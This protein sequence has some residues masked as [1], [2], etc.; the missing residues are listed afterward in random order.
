LPK[1]APEDGECPDGFLMNSNGQCF[2]DKPCP[3]GFEKRDEDETGRCYPITEGP[4][5][6]PIENQTIEPTP[7]GNET[8]ATN[9]T[10]PTPTLSTTVNP[11]QISTDKKTYSLGEMVAI[12]V[13]NNG[14]ETAWLPNGALG[15]RIENL[16]TGKRYGIISTQALV[17]L[18]PGESKSTAWDQKDGGEGNKQY[19]AIIGLV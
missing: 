1:C 9:E 4:P 2:P 16:D 14:N 3:T 17:S 12:T 6:T 15:I 19:L 7:L 8:T 5:P 10:S 18:D 13:K 11:L